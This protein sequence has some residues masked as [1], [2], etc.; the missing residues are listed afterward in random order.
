M[1]KRTGIYYT[2]WQRKLW[3]NSDIEEISHQAMLY[4]H[5]QIVSLGDHL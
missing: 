1:P 2:I 3:L 4:R 5:Q